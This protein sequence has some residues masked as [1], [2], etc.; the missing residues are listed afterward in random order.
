VKNTETV[1]ISLQ[2]LQSSPVNLHKHFIVSLLFHTQLG[3]SH[4]TV[5]VSNVVFGVHFGRRGS[6]ASSNI[7]HIDT[8]SL[9]CEAYVKSQA[10]AAFDKSDIRVLLILV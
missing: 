6:C 1:L 8:I 9:Q 2:I 3:C 4:I 7:S 10:G 5:I